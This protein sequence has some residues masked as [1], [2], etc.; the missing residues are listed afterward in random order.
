VALALKLG[1][2]ALALVVLYAA[3]LTQRLDVS[4]SGLEARARSAE[5]TVVPSTVSPAGRCS[6]PAP[7]AARG[8]RW[9]P[10][11]A[12]PRCARRCS[13]QAALARSAKRS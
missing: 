11:A 6:S 5:A 8:G 12:A 4:R 7:I 13:W 3:W 1:L 9:P 10:Q 2:V